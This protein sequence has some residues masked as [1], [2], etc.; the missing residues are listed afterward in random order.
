MNDQQRETLARRYW[1]AE[2]KIQAIHAGKVVDGD[3]AEI[4]GKLLQLQDEL[5]FLLGVDYF[6]LRDQLPE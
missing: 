5:E 2:D 1:Q 4:E 3:A 6:E